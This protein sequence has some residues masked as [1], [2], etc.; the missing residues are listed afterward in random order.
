MKPS[1][2]SRLTLLKIF[3]SLSLMWKKVILVN[4]R[5]MDARFTRKKIKCILSGMYVRIM[6]KYYVPRS[7]LRVCLNMYKIQIHIPIQIKIWKRQ[8]I[9]N[10]ITRNYCHSTDSPTNHVMRRGNVKRRRQRRIKKEKDKKLQT[11][12]K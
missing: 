4:W 11:I 5:H 12:G 3:L 6:Y 10:F 1:M 2:Y 8:F 9:S 7:V